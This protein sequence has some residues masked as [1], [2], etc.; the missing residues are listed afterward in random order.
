MIK[1]V[2]ELLGEDRPK[3]YLGQNFL[4]DKN[5][6]DKIIK[7]ADIKKTDLILEVGPGLGFLTKELTS[8]AKQVIAVEKD[9]KMVDILEKEP[10]KNLQVWNDD[11]LKVSEAQLRKG[12]GG[13]PYRII[14]NL[15][16]NITS[17]FIR[18]FLETDYPPQEMILM[19]QREVAERIMSTPPNMNLLGI[20]VQF[21]SEPKIEFIVR[22]GSFFPSPKVDS[23][24]I[25][26]KNIKVDKK[27]VDYK[28][29]F[30]I[31]RLGFGQKR[32]Q[33]KNNLKDTGGEGRLSEVGL[34]ET[35]RAQELSLE[36]WVNLVN[37]IDRDDNEF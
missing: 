24:I 11:I 3:K 14:A 23:A 6:I 29:F 32:K 37:K 4:I 20:S 5:I 21:F 9:K 13:K 17:H 2:I 30:E 8:R 7:V 22:P 34:K 36:D 25:H 16:Y 35:V 19:V 33:L 10:V 28:K 31:V 27:K 1:Q 15:P 26:L 18:Q 12:F